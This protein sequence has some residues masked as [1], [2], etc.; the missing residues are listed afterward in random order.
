MILKV[1]RK[2]LTGDS[3]AFTFDVV[4]QRFLVK[5][6]SEGDCLVNFEPITDD[7]ED[8][9]IKIP[10]DIGQI[11]LSN[12]YDGQGTNTIYVKGTGDVEVQVVLW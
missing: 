1:Q 5:N 6:L 9:S 12:E 8:S 7:N 4:G 3:T 11:V 10:K 2:T